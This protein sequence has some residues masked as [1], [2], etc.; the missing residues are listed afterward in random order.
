MLFPWTLTLLLTL[1]SLLQSVAG[2]PGVKVLVSHRRGWHNEGSTENITNYDESPEPYYEDDLGHVHSL[3]DRK[4]DLR[5][6]DGTVIR[7]PTV[8]PEMKFISQAPGVELDSLIDFA[9]LDYA[10]SGV[11]I[12]IH[13]SG[14]NEIHEAFTGTLPAGVQRGRITVLQ[15]ETTASGAKIPTVNGDPS[16]HGTCVADKA[17]GTYYGIAKGANL[18]FIPMADLDKDD[19]MLA[20]LQKIVD[21]IKAKKD[22]DPNFF[23]VVNLSYFLGDPLHKDSGLR[24]QYR[25]KYLAMIQQGALLV[26][27]AGNN[28]D[29]PVDDYPALFAEEVAFENNMI[30]V[31][32]VDVYG[33]RSLFSQVGWLV[34][35]WAPGEIVTTIDHTAAN[36]ADKIKIQGVACAVKSGTTGT[37][38]KWG[39]SFS[40]PQ[41]AGL[42]AYLYSSDPSLRGADAAKKIITKI[43]DRNNGASYKRRGSG[44]RSIWNLQY[45]T[46][47]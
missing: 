37:T 27:P 31:G 18:V 41:V 36:D 42:A 10:G 19:Y 11:T 6:R 32:S 22:A 5:R 44:R 40:A 13:D 24:D 17:I 30:V 43:T 4:R 38:E 14:L 1:Q 26:T 8:H 9:Y 35:T 25:Q 47:C 29:R 23:A 39:T 3:R 46:A 7:Q 12:Y 15:P 21:D 28:G 34:D 16:G 2:F 45:G 20:E 33:Q